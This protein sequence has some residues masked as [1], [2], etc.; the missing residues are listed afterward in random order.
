MSKVRWSK[1][2]KPQPQRFKQAA[3]YATAAPADPRVRAIY[4][5]RA[6]KE[7]MIPYRVALSDYFKGKTLFPNQES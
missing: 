3:E 7:H 6:A 2:Q 4:E 5:K 1:T